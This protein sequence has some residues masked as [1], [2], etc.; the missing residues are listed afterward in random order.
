MQNATIVEAQRDMRVAYLSGGP[1]MLV[2]AAAWTVAGMVATMQSPQRAVWAL[3]IGGMLIHPV[4]QLLLKA[5]GRSARHARGNPFAALAFATTIWMILCLPLAYAVSTLRIEWFFPAMLFVIG[6][7]YLCFS[8]MFGLR[9]YWIC[10]A[11][12]AAAGYLLGRA[13][14]PPAFAAFCGAA[15]EAAFAGAV[16]AGERRG[17]RA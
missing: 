1:G 2:S 5:I 6:G 10:G 12:L 7:R 16:L 4:T 14:A 8:T 11:A 17:A 15:I 13:G 3:F 9:T